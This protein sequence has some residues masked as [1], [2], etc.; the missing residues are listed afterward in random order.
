MRQSCVP[1]GCVT[2]IVRT[3]CR[4]MSFDG[5]HTWTVFRALLLLEPV[6]SQAFVC[7]LDMLHSS[8]REVGQRRFAGVRCVSLRPFHIHTS[9]TPLTRVRV[10][11]AL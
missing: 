8:R 7:V 6:G 9:R 10:G 2:T 5:S 1:P 4:L 11:R 3:L